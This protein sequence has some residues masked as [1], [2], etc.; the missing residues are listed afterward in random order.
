MGIIDKV[1]GLFGQHKEQADAGIDKAG[2]VVD[3]KTGGKFAEQV[4]TGQ[5]AARQG[6]DE[7]TGDDGAQ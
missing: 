2:D 7:L 1:K 6:F 3:D 4:D 5:D